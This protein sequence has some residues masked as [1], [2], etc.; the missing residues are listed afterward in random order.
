MRLFS[1]S[2]HRR[3]S[4]PSGFRPHLNLILGLTV[5]VGSSLGCGQQETSPPADSQQELASNLAPIVK[6][7]PAPAPEDL[8]ADVAGASGLD[9]VHANGMSGEHYFAE[10]MGA[11][12]ALLDYD[13]DGDLDVYLV[14]GHPL[15]NKR[16]S[17][18][19]PGGSSPPRDQL[20]RNDL[21]IGSDGQPQL[22]FTEVT[23]A[24]G[25]DARGYGM[26]AAVGDYDGDGW[27]DLYL[28]NFGP[29]QMWRNRGDGTFENVTEATGTG[30]RRWSVPAAFFDYDRDGRLDLYVGNYVDFTVATH[31]R[32]VTDLGAPDYCGPLAYEAQ[33]DALY[34]NLGDGTFEEVSRRAGFS[35]IAGG[36]LGA[37]VADFDGDTWP[38]LYVGND[39]L[40][41]HLWINQRDGT[42]RDEALLAGCAVNAE[43]QPEASMGVTAADFD[44][45]GDED[46]FMTHLARETNT[47]FAND[48]HGLFEDRSALSGLGGPSL[49]YTGFGTAFFD[50]DNDGLLDLLTVN[51]AVKVLEEQALAGDPFPLHQPNQLFHNRG[52]GR[53]DEVSSQG[54]SIFTL[55]EVSRGAAF[56]DLDNDGDTD[57]LLTQNHGPVRLLLNRRGQDNHWVGLRLVEKKSGQAGGAQTGD[58]RVGDTQGAW[59]EISTR[60]RPPQGKRA[61]THGSYASSGDPRVLFGLGQKASGDSPENAKVPLTARVVVQWAGPAKPEWEV[62]D[63]V[64]IDQYT[65]LERGTGRAGSAQSARLK[66]AGS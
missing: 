43:G 49:E 36:A 30:D 65:S 32:C 35:Q 7:A 26:G 13:G 46:L 37:I 20:Y 6:A 4:V 54:G 56:G 47:L 40:P 61:R 25:L 38:D 63:E 8:F 2:L 17:T 55:S 5:A 31:K 18:G 34:R 12:A 19:G 42:F 57:I 22:R 3:P 21:H 1:K 9:F 62:W 58:T 29:N 23:E 41:N 14:Q 51:G 11:G 44:G 53:F 10:M 33:G 15:T 52:Q 24:A 66:G 64:P 39:G 27:P 16:P 48:G 59:V 60:S 28:T 45:D 50:Y